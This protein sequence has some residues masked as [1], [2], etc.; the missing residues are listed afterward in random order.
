M[1]YVHF[2]KPCNRIHILN[3]HKQECPR[4]SNTLFELKLSYLDYTDLNME[5]RRRFLEKLGDP[6]Q[7]QEFSTVYRMYKYSK[8]YKQMMDQQ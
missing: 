4:C 2:C 1:M 3:G 5:E 6:K 8:W 7:L